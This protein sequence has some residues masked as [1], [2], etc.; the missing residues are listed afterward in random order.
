[1]IMRERER[2]REWARRRPDERERDLA[3]QREDDKRHGRGRPE[4]ERTWVSRKSR[5]PPRRI[6]TCSYVVDVSGV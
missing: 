2:E 4:P 5:S 6:G 3:R 1:M